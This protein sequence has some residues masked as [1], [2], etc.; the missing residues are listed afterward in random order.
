M[1]SKLSNLLEGEKPW[2]MQ[3]EDIDF[4]IG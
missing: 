2:E 3:A 1:R 4:S